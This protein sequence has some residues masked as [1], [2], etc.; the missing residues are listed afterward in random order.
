MTIKRMDS[1]PSSCNKANLL[2][3]IKNAKH[4]IEQKIGDLG[5]RW[6]VTTRT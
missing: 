5:N 2:V 4:A 6:P 3:Y 1:K